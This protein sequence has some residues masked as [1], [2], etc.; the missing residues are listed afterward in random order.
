MFTAETIFN[1]VWLHFCSLY[2]EAKKLSVAYGL[3]QNGKVRIAS[4]GLTFFEKKLPFPEAICWQNWN[5]QRIPF[6]FQSELTE[7]ISVTENEASIN[8]DIIAGAFYFL[9]GWQEFHSTERDK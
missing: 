5:G 8:A 7:V 3:A 9:S 2:P 6:L 1:Y 4:K